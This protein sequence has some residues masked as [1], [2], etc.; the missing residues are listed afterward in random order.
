MGAIED[1]GDAEFLID[2]QT[3]KFRF[4]ALGDAAENERVIQA[5]AAV[6]RR[7]SRCCWDHEG[8]ALDRLVH[9][10]GGRCPG[11]PTRGLCALGWR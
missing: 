4:A 9:L 8:I 3:D 7:R 11:P 5:E 2:E 1:V 6:R 10:G